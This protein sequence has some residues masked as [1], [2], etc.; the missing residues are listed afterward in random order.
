MKGTSKARVA[1]KAAA[2]KLEGRCSCGEVRYRLTAPP[3]IVHACHCRDCQRITGGAFVINLWI[4]TR[5]VE[6]LGAAPQSYLLKG[7]SGAPHEVFFCG[8]CGTYLWSHYGGRRETTFVRAGTL[9]KPAAVAPDVHIYTRSKVP[10]LTLPA[11][12]PAYRSFYKIDKV[13]PPA[14]LERLRALRAETAA[15]R[16]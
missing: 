5:F 7:G 1:R 12:V 14:S 6:S 9:E 2:T 3:L 8:K 13:W 15:A 11:G 16:G 4:E 10:W